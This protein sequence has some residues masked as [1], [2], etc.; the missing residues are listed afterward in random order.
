MSKVI[1]IANQKGGVGK[2][3]TARNLAEG[4]AT[5]GKRVLVIDNDA[6]GHVTMYFKQ[7]RQALEDAG[8]TLAQLYTGAKSIEDIIINVAENIDIVP[9]YKSQVETNLKLLSEWDGREILDRAIKSVASNYDYVLI[10]CPPALGVFLVNALVASDYVL[11]PT[12][13]DKLSLDGI[14]SLVDTVVRVQE[15]LNPNLQIMGILPTMYQGHLKNDASNL[16]DLLKQ[17]E[18]VGV[19]VFDP[20]RNS[21]AFNKAAEIGEAVIKVDKRA[22]GATGYD[23]LAEVILSYE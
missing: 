17:A 3:T 4:F 14:P 6:Q 18:A 22:P 15:R 2:S 5:R 9:T 7:D 11:I 16:T 8:R 21:T 10:D 20:I 13:A 12:K 19:K 23:K 1:A